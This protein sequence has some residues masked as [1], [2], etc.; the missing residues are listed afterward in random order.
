MSGVGYAEPKFATIKWLVGLCTMNIIDVLIIILIFFSLVRGSQVGAV[1]QLCSTAGFFIG[2]VLGALLDPH[3][4]SLTHTTASRSWLS[5]IIT[6]GLALAGLGGGEYLGIILKSRLSDHHKSE[7]VDR[8]LGSLVGMSTLLISVWLG[9][10]ILIALP[11]TGLQNDLRASA[12]I[13]F[14]NKNLPSAPKTIADLS[15]VID[16]NGFPKVFNGTEPA[17]LNANRPLPNIG[18]L[19]AAVNKDSVSVVKVEGS[20]CGGIV[21]GSGFIIAPGYVATNAHVVAGVALPYVIDNNGQHVATAVWF[22]PNLDYAILRVN[23]LAGSALSVNSAIASSGTSAAV[24]GYPGGGSLNAKPAVVLD[25]FVANGSNIYGKGSTNRDVY[26][27]KA[28]VIPG[29][30]GGPLINSKGQVIGLVFAES[31]SYNQVGYALTMQQPLN[32]LHQAEQN[33]QS[34]STGSCAE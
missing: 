21:A 10:A 14:L 28:T 20:G 5:L 32:E 25:E 29:N 27:I 34:V 9:A 33:P 7:Y 22:D 18:S 2:L 12:L 8:G 1:R 26:E 31:T 13:S 19:T 6:L 4:A 16:P 30:S 23:D 17:P 3:L 24:L 11:F 15:R